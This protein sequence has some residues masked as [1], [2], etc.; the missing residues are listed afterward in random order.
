MPDG[1]DGSGH[2]ERTM[3]K[4]TGK[5]RPKTSSATSSKTN[6]FLTWL[7]LNNLS[8][9]TNKRPEPKT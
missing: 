8:K 5:E 4:E 1:H 7:Y 9:S 6:L 2:I 3:A